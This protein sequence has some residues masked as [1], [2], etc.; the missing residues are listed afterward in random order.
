M[1]IKCFK[2][3]SKHTVNNQRLIILTMASYCKNFAST[4]SNWQLP[5]AAALR[6][7]QACLWPFH[8][9]VC[10][11]V[12][13]LFYWLLTVPWGARLCDWVAC[14]DPLSHTTEQGSSQ[15]TCSLPAQGCHLVPVWLKHRPLPFWE[16]GWTNTTG[17]AMTSSSNNSAGL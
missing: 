6:A 9:W 17:W 8:T 16:P 5:S 15:P 11:T 10:F 3:V 1:H 13:T 12:W 7:L 4:V 2:M 14:C